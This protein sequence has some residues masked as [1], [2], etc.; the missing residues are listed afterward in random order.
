MRE[1]VIVDASC[2][3]VLDKIGE[4]E[5]VN[6]CYEKVFTTPEVALEFGGTLPVWIE[7]KP[8]T[9]HT[10]KHAL[11]SF[12]GEGEASAIGLAVEMEKAILI[13]DDLK[14]RKTAL[15][16]KLHLTGTLGVVVKA[17]REKCIESVKPILQKLKHTDFRLS[18]ILVAKIIE[19]A[20]EDYR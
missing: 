3:I 11:G 9:N 2:L 5:L 10:L 17:K 19:Q 20:G 6:C 18:E 13:L 7:I 1:A 15:A 4:L 16:M 12:V 8:L 14:A